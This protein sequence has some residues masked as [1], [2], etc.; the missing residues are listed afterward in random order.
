ME[1][2]T[3]LETVG[4]AFVVFCVLDLIILHFV[5]GYLLR[6]FDKMDE[7]LHDLSQIVYENEKKY[8]RDI[9]KILSKMH[10]IVEIFGK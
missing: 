5:L 3:I 8:D 2:M 4:M 1:E 7:K 10:K 6:E 9:V